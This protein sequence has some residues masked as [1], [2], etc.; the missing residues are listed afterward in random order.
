MHLMFRNAHL[1]IG[2]SVFIFGQVEHGFV[3]FGHN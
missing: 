1:E 2:S 3:K